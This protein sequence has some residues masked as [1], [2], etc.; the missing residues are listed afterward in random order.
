MMSHRPAGYFGCF[1][2]DLNPEISTE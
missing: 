1:C 2:F